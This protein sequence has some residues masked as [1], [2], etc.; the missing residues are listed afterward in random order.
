MNTSIERME[1]LFSRALEFRPDERAAFLAGACGQDSA[2]LARVQALLRAHE[3]GE[4]IL[5]EQP[6]GEL[7]GRWTAEKPGDRIGHYKLL[8]KIGE[9]GFGVVYMAGQEEPVRR[10]VALKV[11]KLGMDTRQVVARFEAERQALALMEHPNIAKVLDAGATQSGRP[12]FVMELVRGVKITDYCDQNNLSTTQRLDLFTQACRAIQHAHQKGIIHRDIKPSN[13][14][15]TVH[16][17]VPVPKVIDFGIAKAT[18]GRLT[19]QTL[20]T[21]FEQFVGTPAYMSPEQAELKGLD[22]DTRTDIYSLG[23]LL[24]ELLTGKTPFDAKDLLAAGLDEMRRTIRE[25]E[26]LRPST[27]LTMEL[28]RGATARQDRGAQGSDSAKG[29]QQAGTEDVSARRL[30]DQKE[31]IHVLR[32]DLDWIVMKCLEKDRTRRYETANGL[33]MDIQRHLRSEPVVAR[34]PSNWYRFQKLVRRNKL[35]FATVAAVAL[36]MVLG[37]MGSTWEAVRARR[38][39]RAQSRLRQEADRA[40]AGEA[41]Q[42]AAAEQHLYDALLG[43]A[44]AKQLSGR[45]GHRFESLDAITKAAA[46]RKS[47]DLSDVAVTALALPDL[48]EQRRWQFPS[49]WV[50]ANVC[51]DEPLELYAYLT[52]S[53]ITVRRV[54]DEQHESFLPVKDVSDFANGLIL[55]R[56]DPRSRYLA[57]SCE[58]RGGGARCRVWDLTRAGALVLDLPSASDPAFTPDGKGIAVVNPDGTVSLQEIESGK[59][60]SRFRADGRLSLVRFSP[61]GMRLAGFELGGSAVWIWELASGQIST[62]LL[63]SG[64]L[65]SLGWNPDGTLLATGLLDGKIDLWDVRSGRVRARMEG[66]ETRVTTLAFSHQGDLLASGSWDSTLRLWN[67]ATA[68]QLVVYRTQDVD[69]HFS[70]DDRTLAYAVEGDTT[71]L[72]EVGQSTGYR[73]LFGRADAPRAW[74]VDF[75]PDGRLMAVCANDGIGLWDTLTGKELG[76]LLTSACRSARFQTYGGLGI[77]GCT[78]DGLYR[79]PIRT[80]STARGSFVRVEAPQVLVAQELFRYSA[81]DANGRKILASREVTA[82]PLLLDLANPTNILKLR[83]HP[84]TQFVALDPQG[85]WAAT[86]T[87]KGTGVK[88]YDGLAGRVLRELPVKGTG[89]VVFSPDGQ[90]LATADMTELRLWKTGSWESAPQAVSGDRVSETNP[91][92]FS[93][94]GRLLAAV[95]GTYEIQL[96]LV[97]SCEV[98]A[99]L[100]VPSL[101]HV[102]S[103]AFSPDGTKFAALEWSGQLDLWDLRVVRDELVKLNLDWELPPLSVATNATPV[104]PTMMQLDAGPFSKEELAQM[105]PPRDANTPADLIDLTEYYNAPLSESWH[106]LK[107]ARND[108][109]ELRPG[110]QKLNGVEF[111]VRGLIQIG[112]AAANRLAYPN[113]V[114][115]IP[116]RRQCRRLHFLHAAIFSGNA[117]VGD[118][119]GSYIL[120]YAD[121]R[122]IELPIVMGKDVA[123]WWSVSSQTNISCA[124]AWTGNNP[125]ARAGGNTIRLFKTTWDNPTPG[126]LIRHF[127]FTS[128]KPT[129]GQP[130]LVAVTAEP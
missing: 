60:L 41:S 77:V 85:R 19:D 113:H 31:L 124:V 34:P 115:G 75:S 30:A 78:S 101:A 38:A 92:A 53:G 74:G 45:A 130:F 3:G 120:H 93:P 72:L 52:A 65:I 18:E 28:A 123:D 121:G 55:R 58:V 24:Y 108:L 71:K 83:G 110:V 91:L 42:R 9:G 61:D 10:R 76:L 17:G 118:E 7:S 51:F 14:L 103:L 107:S 96:M 12:Y 57:A 49:H 8:E 40:R 20:F 117:R 32:G 11:I 33:A 68:R 13:V 50:A 99:T 87:W 46:I 66:H 109:S 4:G 1:A 67:V 106:S 37:T 21:S 111:D 27:R 22:V 59:E 95:H 69:L 82:E 114:L 36:A 112:A 63:S 105:I 23:V 81:L 54:R 88:V 97:P 64:R 126:V 73:R 2:L 128:D 26:P 86:G 6:R 25:K 127:D 102:S 100:R 129:P 90:W 122:Q 47:T 125:S 62:T 94:D 89:F 16:D 70:P 29:N 84:G 98:V 116:V 44:R 39:E 56:F 15:V 104:G 119:L 43:E 79:W 80:E 5:P 48:R 35:V